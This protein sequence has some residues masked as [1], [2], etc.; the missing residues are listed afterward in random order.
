MKSWRRRWNG[1]SEIWE[2]SS[3]GTGDSKFKGHLALKDR[4]HQIQRAPVML[5]VKQG[6]YDAGI[7]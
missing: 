1:C 6:V 4:G 7:E 5:E 2:N 3:E